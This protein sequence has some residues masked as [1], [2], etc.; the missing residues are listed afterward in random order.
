MN[1]NNGEG[2]SDEEQDKVDREI[3]KKL[4]GENAETLLRG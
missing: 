4:W 3:A 1:I 2:L